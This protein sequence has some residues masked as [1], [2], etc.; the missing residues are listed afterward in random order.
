MACPTPAERAR[1]LA[2]GR[3]PGL[4]FL[5]GSASPVPVHHGTG[6]TGEPLLLVP[7]GGSLHLALRTH[8]GPVPPG[9]VLRVDDVAPTA[10]AP[11]LGRVRVSGRLRPVGPTASAAAAIEFAEANPLPSLLGVGSD[12][13]LYRLGVDGVNLEAEHGGG[14]VDPVEYAV[15]EPDP[16]HEVEQDLLLD[17]AD[18]HREQLEPWFRRALHTAGIDAAGPRAAR[19]DRYGFVVDTG[20]RPPARRWVRLEFSRPLNDVDEL[21]HLLHPVLFHSACDHASAEAEAVQA[22]ES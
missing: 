8:G 6:R 11:G 1:T 20:R 15:A 9:A 21:A 19:L 14:P 10:D 18:H 17:L 7:A 12:A 22:P 3:L 5:E 4:L 13:V 2:Q 16:L